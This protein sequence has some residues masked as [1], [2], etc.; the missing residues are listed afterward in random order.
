M[1]CKRKHSRLTWVIWALTIT[2]KLNQIK[3]HLKTHILGWLLLD[4]CVCVVF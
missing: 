2:I 1:K 3:S 4:F